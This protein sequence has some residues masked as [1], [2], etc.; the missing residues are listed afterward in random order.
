MKYKGHVAA[1]AYFLALV[2]FIG[3]LGT[4]LVSAQ[5]TSNSTPSN[6]IRVTPAIMQVQ[7]QP[8]QNSLNLN[9]SITNLTNQP[10]AISLGA[11][12]FG[13]FSQN[14]SITLF[15]S[16]YNPKT[17]PHGIQTNVT[18]PASRVVIPAN[19]TQQVTVTIQNATKL[20]PGGHYGAVLF[21]PQSPL[22]TAGN[23]NNHVSLNTSV[24]GLIFLTTA[25]GGTYGISA[26]MSHL[27]RI[28]FNLPSSTYLVFDNTGNTQTIPQGQLT[29]YGP[30]SEVLG[31][32]VVN[33]SSG[34]I[35]SGGSRIFQVQLPMQ[36]KWYTL[37]GIYHLKLEYKDSKDADF[38][39][40]NQ[41]FLYINWKM[42]LLILAAFVLI[43]YFFNK[44]VWKLLKKLVYFRVRRRKLKSIANTQHGSD[45]IFS[46]PKVMDVARPKRQ[47]KPQ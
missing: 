7:L 36:D 3:L 22:A 29:L 12:D 39:T 35:L 42:V 21:S 24:G 19:E 37:P 28:M 31:T 46:G 15:G 47:K 2:S 11:R 38:K 16:G 34:L 20:A 1:T 32:Q 27:S 41:T 9:Y 23:T 30:R 25:Y 26:S 5:P 6:G 10:L 33:T 4:S 40:L 14:G 17:N 45:A 43:V 8:K 44:V 13:A 18:F